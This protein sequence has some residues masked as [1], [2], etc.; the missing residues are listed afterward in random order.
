MMKILGKGLLRNIMVREGF[1]THEIMLVVVQNGDKNVFE[2]NENLEIDKI[3]KEFPNI[4]TIVI[5]I[6]TEKTNVVLSRKNIVIYGNGIIED[7]L[8]NYVFKISPNSFYQVNPVQ[9]EKLYNLAIKGAK[10]KD[11]D[12]LCDLYCGIGTIGIFASKYVKK[13]Y[14]VEIVEESIKDAKENAKLNGV[15]NIEFIQGDVEIAF[16]KML[17]KGVKP[18]VVIV[19]PPRKGL[20]SKTVK[21]LCVLKLDRLVYVSCNPATLMRD[22][23]ILEDVYK[24]ESI[25]P[26]DNFC[27]SSHVECVCV[28][29]LR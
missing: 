4:R 8:G 22:L 16:N 2:T 13:V 21:N 6:N 24:I 27:Y 25:T 5:N 26:V 11:D 14:G 20:D 23:Q 15:D 12:I 18:S 29:N 1:K 3:L 28:M 10:L 19:D 7:K 9:T 17:E